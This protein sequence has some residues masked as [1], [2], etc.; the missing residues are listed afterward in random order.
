M[1]MSLK[2][3][4]DL[5]CPK[6][7]EQQKCGGGDIRIV[8]LQRGWVVVGRYYEDGNKRRIESGYVIRAWG[9]TRGLGQI[10]TEG[11]TDKTILDAVSTVHFHEQG[12]VA[13]L[14]CTHSSWGEKCKN[15]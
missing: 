11:P 6:Q 9:T 3:L 2:D 12:E 1:E 8:I 10:A 13:S 7:L 5:L 15:H 14:V 4:R